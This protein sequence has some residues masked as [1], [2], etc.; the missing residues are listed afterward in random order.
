MEEA[1]LWLCEVL[2]LTKGSRPLPLAPFDGGTVSA[3]WRPAEGEAGVALALAGGATWRVAA[4]RDGPALRWS[5]GTDSGKPAAEGERPGGGGSH[6][7]ALRRRGAG[8]DALVDGQRVA[9]VYDAAGAASAAVWSASAATLESV[10]LR[11]QAVPPA[12][13]LFATDFGAPTLPGKQKDEVWRLLGDVFHADAPGWSQPLAAKDEAPRLV[14]RPANGPI[15]LWYRDEVPGDAGL[16]V[17]LAALAPAAR[18]ALV[19]NPANGYRLELTRA[20]CRL[21]R[22]EQVV[23]E[24]KLAEAPYAARLQRDGR[25]VAAEVDGHRLAWHD[26]DPPP[27]GK[28]GLRLE[29]G[30]AEVEHLAV[31][32]ENAFASTFGVVDTAW[33]EDGGWLWNTGMACIA[34]SYWI[35][36][37]GRQAPSML[38]RREPLRGDATARVYV[39]EFTEG[40]DRGG[41]TH[42]H[43]AYHD[44]SLVL[45]GDGKDFDS[46]YRF[47]V[48]ADGGRCARLLRRGKVVA[49]NPRFTIVLGG[50][51]NEPRSIYVEAARVGGKLTLRL[52]GAEAIAFDDPEP[53]TAEGYVAIGTERCR[54]NFS[55]LSVLRRPVVGS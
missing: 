1:R 23:G 28:V 26:P 3:T 24:A 45:A 46:G 14:G 27:A 11:A 53:L 8:L 5:L 37:D 2:K 21:M 42:Q 38:W 19:I 17:Q 20:S 7:V 40:Y 47:V 35:T 29:G 48:G 41:E 55:D 43:Y 9:T 50:H 33:R 15:G 52:N 16:S 32:A 51:C 4:R 34:W 12:A 18:L 10:E 49:E 54:A 31:T 6:A 22:G 25:W 39:S 44:V 13:E 30:K 36:G